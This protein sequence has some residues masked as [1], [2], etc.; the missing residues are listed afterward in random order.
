MPRVRIRPRPS[1]RAPSAPRAGPDR[2]RS[3]SAGRS[4]ARCATTRSSVRGRAEAALDREAEGHAMPIATASPCRMPVS[5]SIAW[6]KLWPKLSR[7]RWPLV[8]RSSPATKAGLGA[9]AGLDRVE[10]RRFVAGEQGG[11]I[12][13]APG[14]EVRIADQAV[15]DHLGIAGAQLARGQGG[16]RRRVD[17]HQRRRHGRRRSDSCPGAR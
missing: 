1:C 16:E 12:G 7:A 13:L 4:A 6:P 10:P 9:D 15:F 2:G 3:T 11:A 5:A 8:S 14:E 17:Q